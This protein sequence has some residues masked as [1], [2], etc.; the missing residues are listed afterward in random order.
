METQREEWTKNVEQ[1]RGGQ[2]LWIESTLSEEIPSFSSTLQEKL[3]THMK[4]VNDS[5]WETEN[6]LILELVNELND[7]EL[8]ELDAAVKRMS[9]VLPDKESKYEQKESAPSSKSAPLSLKESKYEQN[10][11]APSSKSSPVSLAAKETA[12]FE[13][14]SQM[15]EESNHRAVRYLDYLRKHKPSLFHQLVLKRGSLDPCG[16]L[17]LLSLVEKNK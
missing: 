2:M 10:E 15:L 5:L 14:W 12:Q 4:A 1:Y 8:K 11:S 6:K 9:P 7:Q 17:S 3:T 16:I 13:Q